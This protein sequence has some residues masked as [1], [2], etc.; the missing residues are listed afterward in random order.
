MKELIDAVIEAIRDALA[1]KPQRQ[2]IPV[3]AEKPK[4]GQMPWMG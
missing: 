3:R 1:P 4:K 2:P